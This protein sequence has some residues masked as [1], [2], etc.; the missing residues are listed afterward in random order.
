[1]VVYLYI[2]AR[3]EWVGEIQYAL[4]TVAKLPKAP[5]QADVRSHP[6][7]E[8]YTAMRQWVIYEVYKS[9]TVTITITFS[10]QCFC[11]LLQ[12]GLTASCMLTQM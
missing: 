3:V 11:T 9:I 7:Q 5:L 1:M 6:T 2:H 8:L 10:S 12:V 4:T